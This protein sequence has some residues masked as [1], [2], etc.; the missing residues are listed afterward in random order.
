MGKY[1]YKRE[2]SGFWVSIYQQDDGAYN[3]STNKKYVRLIDYFFPM[4]RMDSPT[5]WKDSPTYENVCSLWLP[6]GC[7]RP[8]DIEQFK[9]WCSMA[10]NELLWLERNRNIEQYFNNEIDF[11][12][13]CDF[14]IV[15]EEGRTELGEAEYQLK[16]NVNIL[17][18]CEKK[19]YEDIIFDRMMDACK[20]IPL[21]N[22]ENWCLSPMPAT[23]DGKNKLAWRLSEI[24]ADELDVEFVD[25]T[26]LFPKPQMKQLTVD[27]KIRVW[28][29][30]YTN[31]GVEVGCDVR[32]KNVIVV[33]DLYQSGATMWEYAK[34]LKNMGAR[35]VWGLVC[36]KSLRDSDNR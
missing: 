18:A 3:I 27:E 30:I 2:R 25:A 23:L 19:K 31:N 34:Y 32:N 24:L 5:K 8:R 14:N 29:N 33:D 22:F 17:E 12:I 28:N 21:D 35:T 1:Q 4:F 15:Y 13:A 20:Y 16:Y 6:L 36:V 11:C 10:S 9:N 26:L 7:Y